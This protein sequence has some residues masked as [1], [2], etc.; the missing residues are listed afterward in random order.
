MRAHAEQQVEASL[1]A[2]RDSARDIVER[3]QA[4]VKDVELEAQRQAAALLRVAQEGADALAAEAE[5]RRAAAELDIAAMGNR[6]A[7]LVKELSSLRDVLDQALR[8]SGV[9]ESGDIDLRP[10]AQLA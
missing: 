10:V 5:R 4:M 2:A 8:G 7:E 1:A 3:A 9:A 6:R